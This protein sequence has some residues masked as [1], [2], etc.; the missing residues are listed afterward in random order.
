MSS[1]S[2]A[3]VQR[4]LG[5]PRAVIAAFIEAGFVT[6]TFGKRREQRFTFQD[7]VVMKAARELAG[8]GIG[9][10]RIA[11][12]LKRLRA[13]LPAQLPPGGLRISAAG[14]KARQRVIVRQ[15]GAQWQPDS[16]QYLLDFEVAPHLRQGP[17]TLHPRSVSF[18]SA[19]QTQTSASAEDWFARGCES[20]ERD[21]HAAAAAYQQAIE[22]DAA[23]TNAYINLGRLQH[24]QKKLAAAE[25]TYRA[26]LEHAQPDALLLFN[27]G[28][29]LDDQG[30]AEDAVLAYRNALK[31]APD[32][33]D[34]HY[35]LALLYEREGFAREALKHLNT[36]RRLQG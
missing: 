29:L 23:F 13:Q 9:A 10:K 4:M 7:L 25:R 5:L 11:T 12:S 19:Q 24:A 36:Y 1:Y 21:A 14:S 27:L 18:I 22:L 8:S 28:A 15:G 20:E 3:D 30:R 35:N 34:A 6:P 26:G 17:Q 33:A 16:G 32:M 31:L 2:A